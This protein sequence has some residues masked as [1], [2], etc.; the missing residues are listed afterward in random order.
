MAAVLLLSRRNLASSRLRVGL[1][2]LAVMFGV[3][4]VVASFVLSDGLRATFNDIVEDTSVEIDATV[5]AAGD[6]AEVTF[7]A[8]T[9][10][11]DVL[12]V[13]SSVDGVEQALP[14]LTSSKVV[15]IDGD[16]QAIET[17]GPPILAVNQQDSTTGA[18]T[19][20]EGEMPDGPGEFAMDFTSADTYGFEIGQSYDIVGVAG[21]E[22]FTL[23]GTTRFGEDNALAGA[24]LM[25]FT[26]DEVQRL[27]GNDG[28]INVIEVTAESGV[29]AD[30]LIADLEAAVPAGLEAVGNDVVVEEG[31]EDFDAFVD[32]F[33]NVL[34]AF[35][36]VSVFVSTFIIANTFNILLGQRI[37]QLA[38]IRALGASRRQ[39]LLASLLEAFI[40]GVI[41]SIIG[42]AVGVG[43]AYGLIAIMNALGFN[44]PDLELVILARTI[45]IA[46]FVGIGVSLASAL[47]PS[48][49]AARVP[50]VAAMREGFRYGSGEGT[51]RTIIAIILAVPGVTGIAV[52]LFGSIEN[53]PLLLLL[54]GGGAVL[55]FI[56]VTMFAPLFS[57]PTARFLGAPLERMPW[58][59]I[60]GHMARE[61]SSRDNK[62]TAR[63]AAGL[64]IGLAL[65]AMATVVA[66]SLKD[67]VR[68]SLGS[69]LNADFLVSPPDGGTGFS[70]ELVD[71]VAALPELDPVSSTRLGNIRV[72][73]SEHDVRATE[74]ALLT[75]LWDVEVLS[76]DPGADAGPDVVSIHESVATDLNLA[77]GDELDIEFAATGTKTFTVNAIYE[78][79]FLIG[80]YLIDKSAWDQN[81][82]LNEDFSIAAS[83]A[84]GVEFEAAASALDQL[85]AQFPQLN[86]DT[87]DEFSDR[88]EGQLD[89]LLIVINVFLGLAIFIAFLGIANTMALSVLERT[90][91]I[92][93]MRAVGM[94]RRQTRSM[95]RW[96]AAVVSLFGALL[97]VVVGLAFGWVAVQAIPG[98]TINQFAVPVPSLVLY[99]IVATLA[100]LIAAAFPARRASRLNVLDAIHQL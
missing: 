2:G 39:V 42:L 43:L 70:T 10:D 91:E 88:L 36:L 76:G 98:S 48:R 32:I 95:I 81:F 22:P 89:S 56:S 13:V 21:R 69:T 16:G 55:V 44:L 90:R 28:K 59:G 80:S 3:A 97:G 72:N 63:T 100:G 6:F 77:V 92:G 8:Q 94:T 61:N 75:K 45:V 34:L 29:N 50:P 4:F 52:S 57:T 51:R 83:V 65:V 9:I 18:L 60:T 84:E 67:T 23:V 64:M 5:R 31:Q 19:V 79:D 74:L 71:A 35:A 58:L 15:P 26:L 27:D 11:E 73:G 78:N 62:R 20:E 30:E 1:T 46:L 33:G 87:G 38:L 93:L 49:R 41:A 12:D 82:S 25:S 85:Q 99:V 66:S 86:F 53:T 96:E 7:Q 37:R 54:L 14:A 24:V 68:G 40:V 47:T 17:L